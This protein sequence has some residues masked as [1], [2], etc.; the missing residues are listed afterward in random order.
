MNSVTT[1]L[2]MT[3]LL[4]VRNALL[5]VRRTRRAVLDS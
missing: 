1:I 4:V 2:P 5:A 3:Y